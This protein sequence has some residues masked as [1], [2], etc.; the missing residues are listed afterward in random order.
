MV[1]CIKNYR[2]IGN[3]ENFFLDSAIYSIAEFMGVKYDNGFTPFAAITGDLFTYMYSDTIPCDSGLT[4]YVIMP[5]RVLK[6]FE[7][8]GCG[9]EYLSKEEINRDIPSAVQKIRASVDRGIPVLAWGVGGVPGLRHSGLMPEGAL[10]GGYDDDVLLT[11][12]YCGAERLPDESCGGRPGVDEYGYTAISAKEALT[13]S[14]GV[15]IPLEKIQPADP[16]VVCQD[17]LRNIPKWL[18]LSPTGGRQSQTHQYV[19]GKAAFTRWAEVLSDDTVWQTPAEC[20]EGLIWNKHCSAYC[21]L[22][23]STGAFGGDSRVVDWLRRT[24]AVCPELPLISEI[25]PL[26]GEMGALC[27]RIWDIQG[28]FMP[29]ADK[30]REHEYRA[31]IAAAL[32]KM[33]DCCDTILQVFHKAHFVKNDS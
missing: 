31:E 26:Y 14:D 29:P 2:R 27:Q 17:V 16:K 4:N 28:G 20:N 12:L 1:N 5:D 25:L 10:I 32:K 13:G 24:A 7:S 9:C 23:T 33:G 21:S 15:F 30:M 8:I 19:F 6:A 11:H 18:T 3:W 22:C